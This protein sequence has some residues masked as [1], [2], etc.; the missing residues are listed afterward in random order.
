MDRSKCVRLP[1]LMHEV[2][3]APKLEI[4]SRSQHSLLLGWLPRL[5]ARFHLL[6]FWKRA[7]A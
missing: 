6:Q 3:S 4:D 7:K 1:S 2:Q 5:C